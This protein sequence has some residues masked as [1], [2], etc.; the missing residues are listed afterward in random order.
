M[1]RNTIR[2][3][4]GMSELKLLHERKY[5]ETVAR[6]QREKTKPSVKDFEKACRSQ[7]IYG[8]EKI[9]QRSR[10]GVKL[11]SDYLVAYHLVAII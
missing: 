3:Y 4:L 10:C 2:D 8:N 7:V 6:V 1:S 11:A 5:K 9:G